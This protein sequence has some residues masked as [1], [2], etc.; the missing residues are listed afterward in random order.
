MNPNIGKRSRYNR[1]EEKEKTAAVQFVELN[2]KKN[3]TMR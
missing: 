3:I 1:C 2:T